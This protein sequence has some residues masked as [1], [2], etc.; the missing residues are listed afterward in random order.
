[1]SD[2]VHAGRF[3]PHLNLSAAALLAMALLGG[4]GCAQKL[5]RALVERQ[6]D[7]QPACAPVRLAASAR[8]A[9]TT[10]DT[11]L[12][13]AG[14]G[15]WRDGFD[16]AD[17]D[18]DGRLDLLHGPPR[19]GRG[20][21]VIFRGDGNGHFSFW[22]K[23]HFPALPYD[24]GDAKAADFNGDG[25]TDIAL[26][27]HLRGVTVLINEGQG[28]FAPWNEG[29]ALQ[30]PA[31]QVGAPAFTSR[32]I[33][34]ADWNRDGKPDLLAI[35]EGPSLRGGLGETQA[36]ALWFNRDGLWDRAVPEQPLN[37]FGDS[38]AAGDI[39]GDGDI[40]AVLGL[41]ISG[42]RLA[43]QLGDGNLFHSAEL[44][45]LPLDATISAVALRDFD[46]DGRQEVIGGTRALSAG[47]FCTSLQVV[48]GAGSG[49]EKALALWSAKSR[50]PVVAL[51]SGDIDGDGLDDLV[52]VRS[53]GEILSFAGTRRGFSRDLTIATPA[54]M[55]E[56]NAFGAA[57]ADI[58]GDGKL[59]L[60]VNYAGDNKGT[61]GP[62]CASGGFHAWRLHA[63]TGTR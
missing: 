44:R 12:P 2:A 18:G 63:A 47:Q 30:T 43:L 19:K 60:I 11:G 16:L 35:N 48:H 1:M 46:R 29:L 56:C 54:E 13:G 61:G 26:A 24:Y 39:D 4:A 41:Q 58:D 23:A 31:D 49:R 52:A 22:E 25:R 51:A 50:D 32:A 34:V 40:D 8:F 5:P 6:R 42:A 38:I 14:S 21:P 28:H 7:A 9:A 10:L 27:A 59:E 62:Q 36:L 15:Q 45:S 20:Q 53:G 57:L 33:A 37:S 3:L 17:M 55:A